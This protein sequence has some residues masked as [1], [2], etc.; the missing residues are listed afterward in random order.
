MID[1]LKQQI[2][3][4]GGVMVDISDIVHSGR[5]VQNNDLSGYDAFLLINN[6][7]ED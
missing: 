4:A 7:S 2:A 5:V 6:F 3:A 1:T